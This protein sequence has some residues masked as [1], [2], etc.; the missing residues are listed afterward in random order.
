MTTVYL[1]ALALMFLY[2]YWCLPDK[3]RQYL[4]L[5]GNG[6]LFLFFDWRFFFLH[7]LS[8]AINY[9][10]A[11]NVEKSRKTSVVVAV[12]VV[13][14]NFLFVFIHK[15][16]AT[17][18][19]GYLI[20]I[21]VSYYTFV[22]LGYFLEVLR[23]EEQPVKS[24]K[25][26]YLFSAFFPCTMMG[27][28]ERLKN[29]LPQLK[30]AK[31]WNTH[32]AFEGVFLILLGA[33]KKLVIADRLY[34]LANRSNNNA[35]LFHGLSLWFF[36]FMCLLQIYCDFS[37]YVDMARG[38]AK[39]L[40]VDL[41]LN[42]DRPYLAKSVPEIWQ[43]WN[44]TLVS[45][46][47]QHIYVPV[48]L[49]TKSIH[50]A[51][52]V[53][54]LLIGMWHAVSWQLFLWSVYWTILYAFYYQFRVRGWRP[55]R[56]VAVQ[57]LMMIFLMSLSTLFFM[58]QSAEQLKTMLLNLLKLDGTFAPLQVGFTA[59][60]PIFPICLIATA[61]MLAFESQTPEKLQK[62]SLYTLL[63]YSLSLCFLTIVFAVSK[64][65]AFIYMR[66]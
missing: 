61:V 9:T 32:K 49:K 4:I 33:F 39:L 25:D 63:F 59:Q 15:W 11:L 50:I 36:F 28:I 10:A 16:Q 41:S 30:S 8:A 60:N 14:F 31:V 1:L 53:V 22:N 26:F 56:H 48:M 37:S 27:P 65:Q 3:Y 21:G 54:M 5:L 17:Q 57:R 29:L 40:G 52:F 35:D 18:L 7:L 6:S 13:V 2:V 23:R 66:F 46:L 12:G 19:P 20:P 45:W 47:R 42:F 34:D 43:R 24:F 38:F 51:T 58:A 55:L 62:R 44:I 64:S